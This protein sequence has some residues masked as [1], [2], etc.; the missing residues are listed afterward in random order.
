M[1]DIILNCDLKGKSGLERLEIGNQRAW[2]VT[3]FVLCPLCPFLCLPVSRLFW[4]SSLVYPNL[5]GT[6]GYVVVCCLFWKGNLDKA[7]PNAG[8]V[9]LMFYHL[10]DGKVCIC[11]G[12]LF[13]ATE[14]CQFTNAVNFRAEENLKTN[15]MNVLAPLLRCL[16]W[17]QIGRIFFCIGLLCFFLIQRVIEKI[18]DMFNNLIF[19]DK[20]LPS[21]LCARKIKSW[22][23]D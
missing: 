20:W 11:H 19:Q 22:W 16:S 12:K 2:T 9:L 1:V 18:T 5:L 21:I 14:I 7:S 17:S 13:L 15:C 8:Y 10:Y 6:K 3:S 23:C 4:V